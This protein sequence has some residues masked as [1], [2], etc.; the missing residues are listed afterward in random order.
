MQRAAHDNSEKEERFE[1]E[2]RQGVLSKIIKEFPKGWLDLC[3]L[4]QFS[5][6]LW[7]P[8]LGKGQGQNRWA[9]LSEFVHGAG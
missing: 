5:Q 8:R 4:A 9:L 2:V 1:N 6:V 7:Y 3:R